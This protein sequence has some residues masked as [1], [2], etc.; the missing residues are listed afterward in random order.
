MAESK[1]IKKQ[2]KDLPASETK[3][4]VRDVTQQ[5]IEELFGDTKIY[6]YEDSAE[7][8]A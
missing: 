3:S 7:G 6:G 4:I 1:A 2:V 8:T 5:E